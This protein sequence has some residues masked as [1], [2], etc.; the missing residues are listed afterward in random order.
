MIINNATH[1]LGAAATASLGG[2]KNGIMVDG[3]KKG[4]T[5]WP[6]EVWRNALKSEPQ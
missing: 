1:G 4:R 6:Q 3:R 5:G 2:L